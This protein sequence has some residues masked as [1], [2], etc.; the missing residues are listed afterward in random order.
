M[1]IV[2]PDL[3]APLLWSAP[4]PRSCSPDSSLCFPALPE[5]TGR[6]PGAL[7][8]AG[9]LLRGADPQRAGSCGALTK[10]DTWKFL[11]R[12]ETGRLSFNFSAFPP[13]GELAT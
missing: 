9:R 12:S 10:K 1:E 3:P 7:T 13:A 11:R 6:P 8:P 5:V 4:A 2:S